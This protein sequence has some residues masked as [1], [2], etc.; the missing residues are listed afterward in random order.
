MIF[1]KVLTLLNKREKLQV[2][3]LIISF[4]AAYCFEVISFGLMIPLF[5]KVI[6]S[7]NSLMFFEW[8]IEVY[9]SFLNTRVL[10]LS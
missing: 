2:N 8:N 3:F 6:F 4:L 5:S 1:K 7:N 9:L 10:D